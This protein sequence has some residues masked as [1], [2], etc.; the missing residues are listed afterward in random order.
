MKQLIEEQKDC[1]CG[2]VQ[3]RYDKSC[4][5]CGLSQEE[6]YHLKEFKKQLE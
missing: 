6:I 5:S 4:L 1:I 3:F 2:S